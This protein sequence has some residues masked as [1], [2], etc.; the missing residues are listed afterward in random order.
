MLQE[1]LHIA[2]DRNKLLEQQ[3]EEHQEHLQPVTETPAQ[4]E[5]PTVTLER[6]AIISQAEWDNWTLTQRQTCLDILQAGYSPEETTEAI[7]TSLGG[8]VDGG[9][10]TVPTEQL[11]GHMEQIM[12]EEEALRVD[13]RKMYPRDRDIDTRHRHPVC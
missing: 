13:I 5:N 11:K 7:R 2:Q 1:E 3:L 6:P 12:Q 9:Q 10:P 8:Q 4:E